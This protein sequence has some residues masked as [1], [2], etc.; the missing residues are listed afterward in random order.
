MRGFLFLFLFYTG[1]VLS[2]NI[3][4]ERQVVLR[5][6]NDLL[7]GSDRYYSWGLFFGY[8]KQL[9]NAFIFKPTQDGKLQLNLGLGM[10]GH[11]PDELDEE[12]T[13]LFDHPYAGWL[14]AEATVVKVNKTQLFAIGLEVGVT[15]K[16]SLA[17]ELQN[18]Y[19]RFAGIESNPTWFAQ[20]PA[21]VMGNIHFKYVWDISVG[22]NPWAFVSF[23]GD[24]AFGTKDIFAEPGVILSLGKRNRLKNSSLF[25]MIGNSA[26]EN[27]VYLG[28]SYRYVVHNSIIEGSLLNENAP[29]TLEPERRRHRITG[30]VSLHKRHAT[31]KLEYN[32]ISRPTP[33]ARNHDF[34]K[35]I[36]EYN[37]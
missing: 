24:G 23:S 4:Y 12:K 26:S 10:Q 5:H 33:L 37:F 35:F 31:Y 2:Q 25:G 28:T 34:F 3:D 16:P 30:G 9:N 18:W 11:T 27:F 7:T 21:E 15:G 6:D 19:H 20:I 14:F 1:C 13:L 32:Y 17:G 36:F 22:K 8:K 29:F